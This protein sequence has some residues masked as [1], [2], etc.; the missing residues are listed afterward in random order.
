MTEAGLE[1]L[2]WLADLQRADAVGGHFVPIGSNGF[3]EQA[4]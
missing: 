2:C 1:S 3:Y 4:W